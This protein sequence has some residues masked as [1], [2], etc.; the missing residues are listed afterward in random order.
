MLDK[1][2]YKFTLDNNPIKG[3]VNG[4]FLK[5]YYIRDI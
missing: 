5:K 4:N 1:G 3:I 2:I